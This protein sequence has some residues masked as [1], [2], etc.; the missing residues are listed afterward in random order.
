MKKLSE[1][2]LSQEFID[3]V[4]DKVNYTGN[5]LPPECCYY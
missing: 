5:T 4:A 2:K 3:K 1:V